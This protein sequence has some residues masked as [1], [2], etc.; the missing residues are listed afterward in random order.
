MFELSC[1]TVRNHSSMCSVSL[2]LSGLITPILDLLLYHLL[3][4]RK[5]CI[6]IK[7]NAGVPM[8]V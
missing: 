1:D 8:K 4:S 2:L 6:L 5:I 3:Q 7:K